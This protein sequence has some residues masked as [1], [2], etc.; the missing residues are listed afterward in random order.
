MFSPV[1]VVQK[2]HEH[3]RVRHPNPDLSAFP[4]F[5]V[6]LVVDQHPR[7][8]FPQ[9]N[10][11]GHVSTTTTKTRFDTFFK[12]FRLVDRTKFH[13]PLI[14]LFFEGGGTG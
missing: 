4:G 10:K 11:I 14:E 1:Q 8:L 7:H 3:W 9:K 13:L 12:I 6:V 5:L 2:L